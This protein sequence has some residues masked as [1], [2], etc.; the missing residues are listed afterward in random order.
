MIT[1]TDAVGRLLKTVDKPSIVLSLNEL[2][3]GVYFVNLHFKDGTVKSFKE[4]KN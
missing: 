3:K 2:E 4:I 1:I